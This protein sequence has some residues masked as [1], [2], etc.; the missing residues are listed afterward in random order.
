MKHPTNISDAI[1]TFT[2]RKYSKVQL[3][4]VE[5]PSSGATEATVIVQPNSTELLMSNDEPLDLSIKP[6][7]LFSDP[8]PEE[9]SAS[10]YGLAGPSKSASFNVAHFILERVG[11]DFC[12][13]KTE[14]KKNLNVDYPLQ[15]SDFGTLHYDSD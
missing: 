1:S 14:S 5:I 8:L 4:P 2:G 15:G 13:K 9:M 3:R 11:Y 10:N 6:T 7:V 12:L